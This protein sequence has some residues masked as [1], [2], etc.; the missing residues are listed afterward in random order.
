MTVE[1]I[2][3]KAGPYDYTSG[4]AYPFAFKVFNKTDVYV[5][6]TEN[7]VES[8]IT[9]DANYTVTLNDD[10]DNNPGGYVSL[11]T[12]YGGHCKITIGS[13]VPYNQGLVLTNKG[14]FYPDTLNKAYDKLTI[15]CQQLLE[16]IS[17]CIKVNISSGVSADEYKT[18]LESL[19]DQSVSSAA[20][21]AV[22]AQQAATDSAKAVS[23]A[24][25]ALSQSGTALTQ[26]GTALAQSTTALE[27]AV[28]A[29][30]SIQPALE[31]AQKAS[32]D[33]ADAVD[34]SD[35]AL[36]ETAQIDTKVEAAVNE[37]I[38]GVTIPGL[39]PA[40]I[41]GALGYTPYDAETNSK[42]FATSAEVGQ[43]IQ[44]AVDAIPEQ[45]NADWNATEGPGEILNK[46]VIGGVPVGTIE[47]FARE[48]MPQGYLL[49]AGQAVGRATYPELFAAIGTAYGEGDGETTFNLPRL[50]DEIGAIMPFA[51]LHMP[52]DFMPCDGQA[53]S[54]AD[55]AEL[56]TVI[57]TAYG[58]GDGET[59]FNL[60]DL[61]GR[62][63]EGSETPGTVKEAG[64]PDLT[65]DITNIA[66][67]GL[68]TSI[69]TGGFAVTQRA[70]NSVQTGP[71]NGHTFQTNFSASRSNPIY[72]ASD[73]V[74]P[75]ALTV[76][77]GIR[78]KNRLHAAIKAFDAA[79]DQGLV[80]IT[81]LA[82]DIQKAKTP[83]GTVAWF[84]MSSPPVGYLIA[85]GAAVGRATYPDLFAAIGT[86]YGEGD[87][88]TTFNLPD[89]GYKRIDFDASTT[90]LI[91]PGDGFI[92]AKA[93][94]SQGGFHLRNETK[95]YLSESG[96]ERAW[97]LG[98]FVPC[99]KGDQIAVTVWQSTISEVF[100]ATSPSPPFCSYKG[101]LCIKAF[102]ATV[103]TGLIDVTA[104]A[105]EMANKAERSQ[106]ANLAMPS[107][108]YVDL[109]LGQPDV[110]EYT[111]PGDGWVKLEIYCSDSVY[112][113]GLYSRTSGFA[114]PYV[115]SYSPGSLISTFLPV[116]KGDVFIAYFHGTITRSTFRFFY[117]EGSQP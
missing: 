45:V 108:S 72:G 64:L 23:D 63:A 117:A 74:Q 13:G 96:S 77:Y 82:N 52:Q 1:A 90:T 35:Q 16:Q 83:V 60:P 59:T 30:N 8:I 116:R 31:A 91:A 67:G 58:E 41:T 98:T 62:F 40:T 94:T 114:A 4:A 24:T 42:D 61:I 86:M 55:Y 5:V 29:V 25:T 100:F 47:Y 113:V 104:L 33:A 99:Y 68:T 79:V 14:G 26:S 18:E 101:C 70:F 80:D 39:T 6:V 112:Q 53:V 109:T 110:T 11:I 46:P 107:D 28:S 49:A 66:S 2:T 111:A 20:S 57:G 78:V 9:L 19:V 73:T 38:S 81:E 21:A 102:D 17:R 27:N 10:Q 93:S 54:R 36:S 69:T 97:G 75:P 37:A 3:R 48:E 88:E 34:K 44:Q 51:S 22:S 65:G 43:A 84:A 15:L 87:G 85:N 71:N 76:C 50:G 7:D 115:L 56:F 12:Q 105:Q 32:S 95:G 106:V 103:N 89:S 92:F